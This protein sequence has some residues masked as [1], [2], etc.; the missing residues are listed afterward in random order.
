MKT[1]L[2]KIISVSGQQG[3]FRFV[4]QAKSGVIAE[5]L[6]DKKR[7]LFGINSR[8]TALSDISIYTEDKEMPLREVLI[9]IREKLS[10]GDAPIHGSSPEKLREFFADVIPDYDR[11]K[12]Y[13]SHMKKVAEWY[14]ILKQYASLEFESDGQP[15]EEIKES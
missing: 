8:V 9:R 13:V 15:E 12:F 2:K 4:S 14:N 1:D 5:S 7:S 10:D 11:D 6:T 3:L